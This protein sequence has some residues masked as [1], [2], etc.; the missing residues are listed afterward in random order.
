M[1]R[2]LP[3]GWRV[4]HGEGLGL[5]AEAPR[6]K[7]L[8][9]QDMAAHQLAAHDANVLYA[10]LDGVIGADQARDVLERCAA[11]LARLAQTPPSV[12]AASNSGNEPPTIA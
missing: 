6:P 3:P 9:P 1:R 11:R 8:R 5:F 4:L 7:V 2:P 12:P 10:L